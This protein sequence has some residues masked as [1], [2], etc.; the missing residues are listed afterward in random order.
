MAKG[1]Q[2]PS[3]KPSSSYSKTAVTLPESKGFT[4][5]KNR[6]SATILSGFAPGKARPTRY[7]GTGGPEP[8]FPS[9]NVTQ[10][11][12]TGVPFPEGTRGALHSHCYGTQTVGQNA[13]MTLTLTTTETIGTITIA[14]GAPTPNATY[15]N[16]LP[17]CTTVD[18]CSDD[19]C[20]ESAMIPI[21]QPF[22]TVLVTKKTPAISYT[23]EPVGPIFK[24]STTPAPAQHITQHLPDPG[25][26]KPTP[27]AN[28]TVSGQA[29]S[30]GRPSNPV[31]VPL[32]GNIGQLPGSV[33]GIHDLPGHDSSGSSVDSNPGSTNSQNGNSGSA[34][35]PH[36]SDASLGSSSQNMH[37]SSGTNGQSQNVGSFDGSSGNQ[38]QG[39]TP[40]SS[41]DTHGS[42]GSPHPGVSRFGSDEAGGNSYDEGTPPAI[43]VNPGMRTINNVPVS[44]GPGGVVVGTQTILPG[45]HSTTVAV[46]GQIL[47]IEPSQIVAEGTTLPYQI[48]THRPFT[49]MAVGT[50][51]IVLNP[52]DAVIA[53]QTHSLGPSTTTI[54]QD[55]YTYLLG[56]SKLVA[57]H[58]TFDL[59]HTHP[60]LAFVTAGGEVF[61]V[62]S[63]Q[64][65]APGITVAM[66]K[67]PRP[68]QFSH[69][70]ET[71]TI[72]PSQL[73]VPDRTATLPSQN[74]ITP[75]P[76]PIT[77]E[78]VAMSLGPSAVIIG[79]HTYSFQTPTSVVYNHQTI[80][81]GPNGVG[82]TSTT[83][84]IPPKQEFS[85]VT[86]GALTFIVNPSEA[87]IRGHTYM[88][89]SGAKPTTTVING[90]S[91][92]I[93][94][95]GVAFAGTTATL[96]RPTREPRIVVVDGF[97]FS[98]DATDAILSG[99]TY[100]IGRGAK[101]TTTMVGDET[102]SFGPGGVGLPS[103]TITPP[104]SL[105]AV[106]GLTLSLGPT[107][108]AISGTTYD[109]G[110]GAKPTTITL[111]GEA[112]GI[113]PGGIGLP[114]TT[115]VP[116]STPTSSAG[117]FSVV[118]SP[119][120][121]SIP[122]APSLT[123]NDVVGVGTNLR[124]SKGKLLMLST[125]GL[126]V[127]TVLP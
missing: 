124:V 119:A 125:L 28:P 32:E 8:Y 91:I 120:T 23:P 57:A 2:L 103:T 83:I 121:P 82:L 31:A 96:P 16:P 19:S 17:F 114:S 101:P 25:P 94:T 72:N 117:G 61:S 27:P 70:G 42:V 3:T 5:S 45:V 107:E 112:I 1:S 81:L 11:R 20:L 47:T 76:F 22:T 55:G 51:P 100:A 38:F 10:G 18:E 40:G 30:G 41:G 48:A 58:T 4:Y 6:P 7:Y 15:I 88:I 98:V 43:I 79:P 116:P 111:G 123:D 75:G 14:Y 108:V 50:V 106:D 62:Y 44:I 64:L 52:N 59:P 35:N 46:G 85:T 90:Q 115:I 86:E 87:V 29:G 63:S 110:P 104:A 74:M 26:Q 77:A 21:A 73:I 37:G 127:W 68:S 89:T 9:L 126:F 65:E 12:P 93:G 49:T 80:S 53:S 67:I 97:T 95:Q 113:G 39:D 33:P 84:A 34:S 24:A 54:V 69:K 56:S 78:G 122:G 13:F 109:I 118:I 71:F 92:T 66:P 99:T 60:A 102:L 105:V 36:S